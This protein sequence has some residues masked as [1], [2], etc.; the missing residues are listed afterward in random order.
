MGW[1][2]DRFALTGERDPLAE[3]K[4]RSSWAKQMTGKADKKT[5][6]N[7]KDAEKPPYKAKPTELEAVCQRPSSRENPE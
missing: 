3:P 2:S 4:G 6:E 7:A 1:T 5:D